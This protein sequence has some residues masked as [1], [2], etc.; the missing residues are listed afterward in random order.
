MQGDLW[1]AGEEQRIELP[2][3]D[4]RYLPGFIADHE[5]LF[6]RLQA[7]IDWQQDVLLMCGKPIPVPRLQAWYGD[8]GADYSYSGLSLAPKPWI[9]VLEDLRQRLDAFLDCPFNSVLAN[10]YR[11]GKDSVSWHSDDEPE[12]GRNPLIASLSFGATRRFSLR[13]KRS[14]EIHHIELAAG[15]LLVMAGETQHNWHHQIAKTQ[16]CDQPRINLTF[17]RIIRDC[18][19]QA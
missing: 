12:L 13:H 6:E 3:A 7:E 15:S 19:P 8:P 9:A 10:L 18:Q 1:S 2:G 11:D 17:R 14:K 4:I 5:A 16:S